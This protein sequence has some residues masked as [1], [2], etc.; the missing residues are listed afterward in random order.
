MLRCK[1]KAKVPPA[2]AA[3]APA[4]FAFDPEIATLDFKQTG[5]APKLIETAWRLTTLSLPSHLAEE[6]VLRRVS[7]QQGACPSS[8]V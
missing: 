4:T 8:R 6:H 2:L 3:L 5:D 7:A 1:R